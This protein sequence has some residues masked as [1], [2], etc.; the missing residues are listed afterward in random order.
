M[1]RG[2]CVNLVVMGIVFVALASL[3]GAQGPGPQKE[4]GIQAA[5]GTGFTYQGE[6][7]NVNGPV[8]GTCDFQFGLW[9]AQTSG[10]PVGSTQMVNGV[11]VSNGRFAVQLDFGSVF[12]G[13]ARFLQIAVRCPAGSGSYTTLAP[14]QQLTAAPYAL[15]LRPGAMINGTGASSALVL[16]N[17]SGDGLRVDSA[18]FD[19]V[20]VG[21]AGDFGVDVESRRALACA[22][23]R[24]PL[25][26]GWIRPPLA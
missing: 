9:D 16:R 15:S 25:A 22:C 19:G 14:R 23:T 4:A 18:H 12:A 8:T 17:D 24:R 3:A 11:S 1:K 5:V 20:Y 6:L 21:S 13:D 2:F 7:R 26:C 10:A